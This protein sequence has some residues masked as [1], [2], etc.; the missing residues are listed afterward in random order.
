MR[1]GTIGSKAIVMTHGPS[2]CLGK[3]G[4]KLDPILMIVPLIPGGNLRRET[5]L[6]EDKTLC[7]TFFYGF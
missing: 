3:I 6:D 7:T 5:S 1:L 2:C 4:S